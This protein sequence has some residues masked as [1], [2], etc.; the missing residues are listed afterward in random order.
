MLKLIKHARDF[1][2]Y[3]F[4]EDACM[5]ARHS[6]I[7]CVGYAILCS[8]FLSKFVQRKSPKNPWG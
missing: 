1:A 2:P 3:D 5:N 8:R 7:C 4:Q 6:W